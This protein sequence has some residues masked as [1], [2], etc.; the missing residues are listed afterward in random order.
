MTGE[1]VQRPAGSAVPAAP[2][3]AAASERYLLFLATSLAL[4]LG[5]GFVLAILLPVAV[6][7]QASWG[8]RWQA[9][10]QVHGHVQVVGFAG[11]FIA[12]MAYRLVPRFSGVPLQHPWTVLPVFGLLLIGIGLRALAQP[13]NDNPLFAWGSA[14]ASLAE[15][16][17]AGLFCLSMLTTLQR[18]LHDRQHWALFMG[19]GAI[20]FLL[21]A[22]CG[23]WFLT[24]LSL[25]GGTANALAGGRTVLPADRDNLL[26]ALQLYGFLLGF[27]FG[28]ASRAVPT[29]FAHRPPARLVLGSWASLQAGLLLFALESLSETAGHPPFAR[30]QALGL[31]GLGLG[32]IGGAASTGS[33]KAAERLRPSARGAAGLLKAAFF[34]C[35]LAGCLDVVFAVWDLV[36]DR[37]LAGSEADA[38]RHLLTVGVVTTMIAAMGHLVVPALAT[39]RLAGITARRRLLLLQR[40]LIAAVLLRATPSLLTGLSSRLRVSLIGV[41]GIL[42]WL[43]IALFAWFLLQARRQQRGTIEV[44]TQPAS[45]SVAGRR[46]QTP[47]EA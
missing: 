47:P 29:F 21:Q 35:A 19:A 45:A 27:I 11:L 18:P 36:A 13:L 24:D 42:A 39:Q 40:L 7:L 4:A 10:A 20:W 23:A 14:A 8:L 43:A 22:I 34:W 16:A 2:K 30:L 37:S 44:F 15:L 46:L 41:S 9:L 12:G 32:L 6:S 17:G 26:V 5:L 3:V 33:W 25:H 1:M 31:L 28:V 38:V